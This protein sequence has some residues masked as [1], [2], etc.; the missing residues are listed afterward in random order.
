MLEPAEDTGNGVPDLLKHPLGAPKM[1]ERNKP[2][3]IST[4]N[5]ERDQGIAEIGDKRFLIDFSSGHLSQA[6][7]GETWHGSF[8]GVIAVDPSLRGKEF[9]DTVVHEI[10]HGY[11]DD[12]NL[13]TRPA[14]KRREE[15]ITQLAN[16]ISN[17]IF[18]K[19]CLRRCGF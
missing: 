4:D 18:T 6:N 13:L 17:V 7:Y 8:D 10:L 19:E 3:P 5:P 15:I 1:A 14:N 11:L 2:K 12:T 16:Q 9:F